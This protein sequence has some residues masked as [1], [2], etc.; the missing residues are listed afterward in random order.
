M[1]GHYA[2]CPKSGAPLSETVHYDEVGRPLRH[3]VSDGHV[4]KTE[5]SGELTNGALR[6]SKVAVFNYF[7]R[8]HQRHH[9]DDGQLYSKT[10]V[11][12]SRLKRAASGTTEWDMYVWFAL[13]ER[14]A[15]RGFDVGWMN[16]HIEPRC[17]HCA[18]RLSYDQFGA[19]AITARCGT[20]CT[21]DDADRLTE[22]RADVV[23]LYDA[24][25]A[26]DPPEPD[27]LVLL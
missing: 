25:F 7:R 14:L 5:P 6:S 17:P 16:A 27:E 1:K 22:I 11:A 20:N 13:G 18:G 15:E 12:L 23:D 10:A 4:A 2:F 24:A 21:G 9:D 26:A 3:A 8:C 19:D